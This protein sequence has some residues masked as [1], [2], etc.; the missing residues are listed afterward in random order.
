MVGSTFS[1]VDSYKVR[2]SLSIL[3]PIANKP[4]TVIFAIYFLELCIMADRDVTVHR[5]GRRYSK[6]YLELC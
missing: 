3:V 2:S 5:R 4:M 6:S 1:K